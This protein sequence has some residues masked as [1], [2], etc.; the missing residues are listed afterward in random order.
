[1]TGW[2]G[3]LEE[4]WRSPA[5]HLQLDVF[6]I[7]TYD[8]WDRYTVQGYTWMS[9]HSISRGG[10]AVH[11]LRTWKPL[12]TVQDRLH[13]FFVSG[14][15]ELKDM[16][17]TG[18]PQV[19]PRLENDRAGAGSGG[20]R[21]VGRASRERVWG[22]EE[23][24]TGCGEEVGVTETRANRMSEEMRRRESIRN[25]AGRSRATQDRHRE[26]GTEGTSTH[27]GIRKGQPVARPGAD[28]VQPW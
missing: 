14:S 1:M 6:Q 16:T 10:C 25:E 13:S 19:R 12:G 9:L 26:V 8:S 11:R 21:L 27:Q 22:G 3:M 24:G 17:Y 15:A 7:N 28:M 5:C 23:G 4:G 2:L 18:L 20:E